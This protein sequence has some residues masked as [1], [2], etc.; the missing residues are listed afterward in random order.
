LIRKKGDAIVGILNITDLSTAIA[1]Q[2]CFEKF[3][4]APQQL[5]DIRKPDFEKLLK[6]SL[7]SAAAESL[8]GVSEEGKRV[9]EHPEDT[10][11]DKIL[12]I[13]SKGV[14]RT[15]VLTKAGKRRILSQSDVVNFLK[16]HSSELGDICEQ[17]L[18]K[19]GLL[20]EAK[21]EL[22]KMTMYESAL[23]GFQR[24][25]NQGWEVLSLP[26]LDKTG[27]IVATLSASELRGLNH[28]N[29]GILLLPVLDFLREVTGGARPVIMARPSAPLGE[30][31]RK[32]VFG[33]V[34][35]VWIVENH[36]ILGVVS[37]SD[38]LC[39]FSPYDF[40]QPAE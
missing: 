32:V 24:L 25:Y 2:G 5:A 4:G 36:K 12:E 40:K 15:I 38:I 39:K 34:H 9:W 20:Q 26:I 22:V 18:N 1:F 16:D 10:P 27:D 21:G 28:E 14:H 13:F 30:V 6:T 3:K 29:F 31:I 7:F 23:V 11:L 19:L 37:L 8:L 17:P 33:R 35:R